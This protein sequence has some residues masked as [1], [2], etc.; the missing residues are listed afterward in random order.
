MSLF[1]PISGA[2]GGS[3]IGLSAGALLLGNGDILGCSGIVSSIV[4]KPKVSKAKWKN[5]FVSTF[6]L[7]SRMLVQLAGQNK[8]KLELEKNIIAQSSS[9]PVVSTLGFCVAGFL[10]GFGTRLGNGCTTGHGICGLARFSK[11]S[12]AAVLTFMSTG[13]FSAS[14][15]SQECKLATFLRTTVEGLDD[16]YPNESS[17]FFSDLILIAIT[18]SYIT[19]N[20][21]FP[22]RKELNNY[23]GK[24][25]SS[26]DKRK[27]PMAVLS[28]ITFSVGLF[29][30]GMTK[31][32]KIYHF[33]DFKP[34]IAVK[35]GW[36]P[37]LV[38]VM[39][40]GLLVSMFSYHFVQGHNILKNEHVLS[41]PLLQ[42]K[43]NGGEF[44]VPI[45]KKIDRQLIIGSAL[46][47]VGWGLA[48]LCPGP[49]LFLAANGYKQ[50]LFFWWPCNIMGTILGEQAK[51]Y[52]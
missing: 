35:R 26:N 2:I 5:I 45:N 33:L 38:F 48:G 43:S 30:S 32:F 41:C 15:C 8:Q 9:L 12:F 25:I 37:T 1:T 19:G 50:V 52:I 42:D 39:G 49:A 27:G 36:D 4:L 6:L 46:F 17:S 23:K 31:N 44:G 7:T 14:M 16:Y 22:S 34:L 10:V 11:R 20:L 29:I 28:A 18:G 3:L 40:G 13:I 51:K 47:G 24:G 21:F